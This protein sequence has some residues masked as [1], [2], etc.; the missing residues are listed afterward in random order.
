MLYA[1]SNKLLEGVEGYWVG[2]EY[3]GLCVLP[4]RLLGTPLGTLSP[5]VFSQQVRQRFSQV[6]LVLIYDVSHASRIEPLPCGAMTSWPCDQLV[7][8]DH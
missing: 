8:L 6:C 5:Q 3:L 4:G 2:D 1:P 7:L